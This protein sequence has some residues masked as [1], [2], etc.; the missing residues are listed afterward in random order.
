MKRGQGTVQNNLARSVRCRWMVVM[1]PLP[2]M[3]LWRPLRHPRVP[4][5][6]LDRQWCRRPQAM[7][8]APLECN[9]CGHTRW[10]RELHAWWC[11]IGRCKFPKTNDRVGSVD[12][13]A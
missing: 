3:I 1:M 4:D 6:K 8:R 11:G 12:D 2:R 13:C 5:I 10:Q 7:Q 9:D